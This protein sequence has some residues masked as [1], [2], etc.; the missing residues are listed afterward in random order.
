MEPI[1]FIPH[2][3]GPC[4]FMDWTMGPAD[5]W[6]NMA[7]FLR[8]YNTQPHPKAILL[9]S[10]HWEESAF[11]LTTH[12]NPPLIYDYSGFP[13][14][15][16][17]LEYNAPGS[18]ALAARAAQLL[19]QSN[20]PTRLDPTRGWDHGVFLPLKLMYPDAQ[21][22][23]V[24]LSLHNSLDPALHL[25][26]GAALEPLLTEGVRIIASGMSYHNLRQFGPRA[27]A[28]SEAFDQWLTQALS[29]EDRNAQLTHWAAAPSA[30]DA[31]PREEHLIPLMVAAGA[32]GPSRADKIYT[33][34]VMGARVSAFRLH[35]SS[36]L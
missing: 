22:P 29:A 7:A 1:D 2:G 21:I 13:P 5:T 11:S 12:P 14:H 30:R 4:F 27:A 3:G 6:N 10:G 34:H 8:S 25:R 23:I 33:D 31:H 15:T 20:L 28:P 32:A 18:P 17:K 36:T 35:P 9:V 24:Q 16:Y 19:Q 26:A